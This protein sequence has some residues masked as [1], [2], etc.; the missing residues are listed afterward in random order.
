MILIAS[1]TNKKLEDLEAKALNYVEQ[2]NS[3][4]ITWHVKN[5]NAYE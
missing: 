1:C 5:R 4:I 3:F 2:L